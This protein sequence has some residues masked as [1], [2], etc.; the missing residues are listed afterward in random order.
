LI[1]ASAELAS[2][3]RLVP[4]SVSAGLVVSVRDDGKGTSE[5]LTE[6]LRCE[7]LKE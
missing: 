2:E 1:S 6:E 7:I 4:L 5:V 3:A